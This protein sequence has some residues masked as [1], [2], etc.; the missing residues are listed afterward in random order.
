MNSVFQA[1]K[2]NKNSNSNN[3]NGETSSKKT[4]NLKDPNNS[5]EKLRHIREKMSSLNIDDD[6]IQINLI[7]RIPVDM[8]AE[9]KENGGVGLNVDCVDSSI[10]SCSSSC[11]LTNGTNGTISSSTSSS[12]LT[13]S[14]SSI[15]K[16]ESENYSSENNILTKCCKADDNDSQMDESTIIDAN[17]HSEES[18]KENC[19]NVVI[20]KSM[21]LI[22]DINSKSSSNILNKPNTNSNSRTNRPRLSLSNIGGVNNL[23]PSVH[24]R[25]NT[26]G[27]PGNG[28][29][30][31][32]TRLS[33]HQRNLSLDFR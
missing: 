8:E 10:S 24:G 9:C 12:S 26:N 25:P 14:L 7:K 22:N 4:L 23:M 30:Q 31:P 33:T 18:A 19:N 29:Q 15:K 11:P 32:R 6:D 13:T 16:H 5:Y 3:A 21:P 1:F 20:I 17:S 2:S 27:L 28:S